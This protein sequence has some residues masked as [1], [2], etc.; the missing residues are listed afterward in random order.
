MRTKGLRGVGVFVLTLTIL[1]LLF[2]ALPLA[3]QSQFAPP[4]PNSP[5]AAE[6]I[7]LTMGTGT[8]VFSYGP[9]YNNY[10]NNKTQMLYM[11][12]EIGY[13]GPIK[14]IAFN[15]STIAASYRTL[16]NFTIRM[17]E[18]PT[19]SI[20]ST[21]YLDTSSA[22]MV[23]GGSGYS[24]TMP[25]ATGWVWFDIA[26]FN[27]NSNKNLL[28][29]IVWGDNGGYAGT[30]Y[31]VYATS[32]SPN[33]RT[34]Y[35]YADAETPPLYD[36]RSFS[37]PNLRF[38]METEAVPL[39]F[40]SSKTVMPTGSRLAGDVVTYTVG[41][42][43]SGI[44]TGTFTLNDPIPTGATYVPGSVQGG[45]S[46]SDSLNAVIMEPTSLAV[47][48]RLTVT[49]AVT[50]TAMRGYVTN[51]ATISDP[52][53]LVPVNISAG[54]PI[55]EPIFNISTLMPTAGWTHPGSVV[56]YTFDV[57]N[58]SS[59]A[60]ATAATLFSPIPAG[61]TL[62]SASAVWGG[63][64]STSTVGITWTG[65]VPI[66][67]RAILTYSLILPS[68]T[69][70][71]T[72]TAYINDPGLSVPV[73]KTASFQ[74]Q[75]PTGGPTA[76]GY[77]YKDSYAA[78]GPVFA[79]TEPLTTSNLITLASG[80]INDGS[81]RAELPFNF[82]F[83]TQTYSTVYA[84]VNGY[85]TF[86]SSADIPTN[87]T[88]PNS[89]TPNNYAAC[90]WDDL[91]LN[92]TA[93][94]TEGIYYEVQGSAPNRQAIFTFVVEDG[95]YSIGEMPPYRF[96]MILEESTHQIT[97]QY[98][99]KDLSNPRGTGQGATLGLE[100]SAGS[101]GLLYFYG[102]GLT[103]PAPVED[104]L[105]IRYLPPQRPLYELSSKSVQPAALVFPGDPLTYTVVVRNVG[106][107]AGSINFTDPLP[108]GT[109]FGWIDP[110]D[111]LPTFSDGVLSWS[112]AMAPGATITFTYH[113]TAANL[114]S[115][116]IVNTAVISD[117]LST[118]PVTL[119]M[120]NALATPKYS[121]SY[122]NVLPNGTPVNVGQPLTYTLVVINNGALSGTATI[123]DPIPAG[124]AYVAASALVTGGGVLNDANGI[125][126][127]GLIT[128][129]GRITITFNA[130]VVGLSG[131]ITNSATISDPLAV[132]V[133]IT[134]ASN[135]INAPDLTASKKSVSDLAVQGGNVVTY[136][137]AIQNSG[138]VTA[139]A[140]SMHDALPAGMTANLAGVT[141]SAGIVTAT[142]TEIDWSGVISL[143]TTI[144]V[145][146][147][148]TV[149]AEQCSQVLT[150]TAIISEVTQ[151]APFLAAAPGVTVYG[152][153]SR[154]NESF[155]STTFPPAGWTTTIVTQ[156]GTPAWTREITGGSP[157][158][159]SGPY[160]GQAL[161][162]FNSYYYFGAAVR[163]SSN[164]VS[165]AG[166]SNPLLIFAMYHD[167]GYSAS[168]DRI[169]VQA[170]TDGTSYQNVGAPIYRYA[171]TTGEWRLHGVDLSAYAGQTVWVGF[172]A[173]SEA[174]N[175]IFLDAVKIQACCELPGG[176]SFDFAPPSPMI[177]EEVTFNGAVLTGTL[178]LTYSWDFGDGSATAMG[179]PITHS[180]LSATTYPVTLT[181]VNR[182]GSAQAYNPV[183]ILAAP[184]A[185]DIT[186]VGDAA[187]PL[188]Q[189]T[190]FT[191]T[192][193]AGSTPITY[194]WNFGDGTVIAGGLVMAH[195]YAAGSYTAIITAENAVGQDV[196]TTT[197]SIGAGPTAGFISNSP[198]Y[199]PNATAVFT[200]TG[201]GA[202]S[203]VW[204]FGDGV[205]GTL[206]NPTHTYALPP[207]NTMRSYIVTQTAINAFASGQVTGVVTLYNYTV[208]LT[209]AKSGPGMLGQNAPVVYTI[210]V[211]NSGMA[212]STGT[213][214][215]DTFP[216]GT[217]GP[218]YNISVNQGS[219]ISNTTG[220]LI[221]NG[222]VAG[223][224]ALTLSFSLTPTVACGGAVPANTAVVS[225]PTLAAPLNVTASPIQIVNGLA[226]SEGFDGVLFPP[227]GWGTAVITDAGTQGAPQWS[228]V[229]AGTY[230]TLL[231][232]S[233][234]G[235]L[236]YNS[237]NSDSGDS[238]RLYT[239]EL[240]FTALSH[241]VLQFWMYHDTGYSSNNDRI[242]PQISVNGGVYTDVAAP[243][244]RYAATAH[245][246]L[247]TIDL[248]AY[249]GQNH[250][251]VGLQAI[252]A[253]GNNM[254]L[255]EIAIIQPCAG[256]G[257]RSD[258]VG[259]VCPGAQTVYTLTLSNDN[260][261]TDTINLGTSPAVPAWTTG[262]PPSIQMSPYST[263]S[264]TVTVTAPIT[265]SAGSS[266][267]VTLTAHAQLGGF[268]AAV[269]IMTLINPG[270][271]W[272]DRAA[273][274]RAVRYAGITYHNG[275]LYQMGG[276]AST[277]M[278]DSVG[279]V[280]R[281]NLASNVWET[282]TSM[283]T[284]VQG[285]DPVAIGNK[286]YV[287]GG[288]DRN[289]FYLDDLQIYDTTVNTWT[290]GARLTI[291]PLWQYQAVALDGQ[292]YIIGGNGGWATATTHNR[293]FRYNPTGNSWSEAAPLN[294]A[295][296]YASAGVIGGKIYIAGGS[297]LSALSSMEIYDTAAN[298]WT[299]GVDL[300]AAWASAADA[301]L[302]DR[303]LV[304][305]GGGGT[306]ATASNYVWVYDTVSRIW[307][308]LNPMSTML[309]SAG[310]DSD[311]QNFYVATGRE[312]DGSNFFMSS[313]V[314]KLVSTCPA[315]PP[316]IDITAPPAGYEV[317]LGTGASGVRN[318]NIGNSGA[319]MLVYTNSI[320]PAVGWLAVQ[321][322]S[323]T[324]S[325]GAG[326][327][328]V[329]LNF[330]TTGLAT[331]DY[332][333]TLV[334]ASNDADELQ[335]T[336]PITLH[337]LG[338]CTPVTG[339]AFSWTPWMP[340]PGQLVTFTGSTTGTLPYVYE[341]NFGDG[342]TLSSSEAV[343]THTY[344]VSP[345]I[346][347]YTVMLTATNPCGTQ[348][349]TGTVNMNRY[350]LY[351]PIVCRGAR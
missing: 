54:N 178:P 328:A 46:Y 56:T 172:L 237:Y 51:T 37:R 167:S 322:V 82:T 29:E 89:G 30:Y 330:N 36:G 224:Q 60:T 75:V 348:S 323:G 208:V 341:W 157:T 213:R 179:N 41:V 22:T 45:A 48:G 79:W 19:T 338:S 346:T 137:V 160:S 251:R 129:G 14:R 176:A 282:M 138:T 151:Q 113:V 31:Q 140:A 141:A 43:N 203:W 268:D 108:L 291:I 8:T 156:T 70:L 7:T 111:P 191:A 320:V 340:Q 283:I 121:S 311:G 159:P 192:L 249:R 272:Q 168:F 308:Q 312:S 10:E 170:S 125:G 71:F 193:L 230:P 248:S 38:E 329:A 64:L 42:F 126:W 240:D 351:L 120:S 166:V 83:F 294:Q 274:P 13:S 128:A 130:T 339:T 58:T 53:I 133:T 279:S 221:W 271:S 78:G 344:P 152:P 331:G 264:V 222:T 321:P 218:A 227:T 98:Q 219:V 99:Q 158:I 5:S 318:F 199:A 292:L 232:Y 81:Y 223:G 180:Y 55:A 197:V 68:T 299:L 350:S 27:F 349:V 21:A 247:H 297:Y 87:V 94:L 342:V 231:P 174:G 277:T 169:Q 67:G 276:Q 116:L 190:N 96:Q 131:R 253:Y 310:A 93:A 242:I 50:L 63:T 72:S 147:P 266:D 337:V 150:N 132:P 280:Y 196:A 95:A 332:T 154:L 305:A 220:G 324:I 173:I 2:T 257:L 226:L 28:I 300:P 165:L 263:R 142:A 255:D 246:E 177:N 284:P 59:V 343:I 80:V 136:R 202:T 273:S 61:A 110:S 209:A 127:S 92:S 15:I 86:G 102:S 23:Y 185:P 295:R 189:A 261:I 40:A 188:G 123:S 112:G 281:L 109:T 333:T 182:C 200:D 326:A 309:Y 62:V 289:G 217:T 143:Y 6:L 134:A 195:T 76:F 315:A 304:M 117:P 317:S 345:A 214:I 118:A 334:V 302:Y 206:Q 17:M 325:S 239:G 144:Y 25:S 85:L 12:S 153:Y 122:K 57:M 18:I 313:R 73:T 149:S 205:T 145:T 186:L 216:A 47:G 171:V 241:P 245:W 103:I 215:V 44:T 4:Q 336:F 181:V 9:F 207:V 162:K 347:P 187:T 163:L 236:K 228:R 258:S 211:S 65:V 303:Y 183:T 104:G 212:D 124:A 34:V 252:G 16:S 77:T 267:L 335:T 97:C 66:N 327:T 201:S 265:A 319:G 119:T 32:T 49:F 155:E 259:M 26:D 298:T 148:V 301:V 20:T 256:I 316:E 194:T 307:F 296:Y 210:V 243:I 184:V 262:F 164:P 314:L 225:A 285:I 135:L 91:K 286:I 100:N 35:G 114:V 229:A 270:N 161:A 260:S 69:G 33:Y 105:A 107:V 235:M 106:A 278:T 24:E 175:N 39:Y 139:Y 1:V 306:T 290:L 146:I 204:N 198:L 288:Y 287:F 11:G 233:G 293:V 90:Y 254:Y 115:G 238:V 234:A 275:Y 101:E 88:I 52:L 250:I 269:R 84:D 74:M 244:A 3:A